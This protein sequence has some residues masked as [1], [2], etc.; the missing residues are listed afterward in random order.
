MQRGTETILLVEDELGVRKLVTTCLERCGYRVLTACDGRE[1]MELWQ[2][3]QNEIDLLFTD[4]VM[5]GGIS[6]RQLAERLRAD[7]PNLMVLFTT[8]YS[9]DVFEG[10]ALEPRQ[11]LLPKPYELGTL[12][13]VVREFLDSGK[14]G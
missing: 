11:A 9:L 2:S 10:S 4:I 7:K 1:A 12:A 14:S 6:G 13:K 5:P 3:H 8:G